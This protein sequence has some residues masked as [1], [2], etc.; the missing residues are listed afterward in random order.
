[1]KAN[2]TT[3]EQ[4]IA[5][6]RAMCA[7]KERAEVEFLRAQVRTLLGIVGNKRI[8]LSDEQRRLLAKTGIAARDSLAESSLIFKP[9]TILKWHRTLKAAKK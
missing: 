9:E 4:F 3:V 7:T 5:S 2:I 1:M 6:I 8:I